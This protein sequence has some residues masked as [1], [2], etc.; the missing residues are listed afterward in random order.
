MDNDKDK[1]VSR[2]QALGGIGAT[3]ATVVAVPT[4]AG[5]TNISGKGTGAPALEGD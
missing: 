2:R 1:I 3:L 5:T 4:F